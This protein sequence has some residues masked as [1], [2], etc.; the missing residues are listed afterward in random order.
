MNDC[1]FISGDCIYPCPM[2]SGATL[3]IRYLYKGGNL[4]AIQ[5]K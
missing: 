3:L 2:V 1:E 4:H 5:I